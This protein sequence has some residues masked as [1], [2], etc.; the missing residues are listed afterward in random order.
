MTNYDASPYL[1]TTLPDKPVEAISVPTFGYNSSNG[2][3]GQYLIVRIGTDGKAY[4]RNYTSTT[5]GIS[6]L[7]ASFAFISS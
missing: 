3:V 5:V 2:A 1:I 7:M 4:V 6:R